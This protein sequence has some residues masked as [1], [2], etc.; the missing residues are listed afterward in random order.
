[1]RKYG[2]KRFFFD[3]FYGFSFAF[4]SVSVSVNPQKIRQSRIGKPK[5]TI[6]FRQFLREGKGP[7]AAQTREEETFPRKCSERSGREGVFRTAADNAA[8]NFAV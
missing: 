3:F 2:K 5:Y 8:D 1:M 7:H 4:L 6:A